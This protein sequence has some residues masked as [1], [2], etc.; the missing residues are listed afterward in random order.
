MTTYYLSGPMRGK[1]Y[2]NRALFVDVDCALRK[3][4]N[5]ED[6]I[7]NPSLNFNG[8]QSLEPSVYMTLDLHQVLDSDVI[9]LLPGWRDSSGARRE[10]QLAMWAGKDF[11]EAEAKPFPNGD[12]TYE[13]YEPVEAI[14]AMDESQSLR[15]ATLDKAKECITGDRN[16]NYGPP[17]QDFRRSSDAMTA[18]GYRHTQLA[19]SAPMCPTCGAR[20]MESHDTAILVDC[21][22]TSRI[23]WTPTKEDHWIDKAGYAGCGYECA[24][25]DA[26]AAAW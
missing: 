18:Y 10:V 13:F 7:I 11:M 6:H 8:D 4:L 16:N 2:Y 17:H 19:A 21:V 23:M 5:P 9:V 22:K 20:P 12:W 25:E 14:P 3:V 15:A 26:K 1:P 24:V